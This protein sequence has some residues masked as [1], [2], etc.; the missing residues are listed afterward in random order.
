MLH[1]P[2]AALEAGLSEIRRSPTDEGRVVLIVRRPALDERE[3]LTEAELDPSTGLVGDTWPVR[4]SIR[5]PDRSPHPGMQLNIMNARVAALVAGWPAPSVVDRR[6][7]AGDQF[8]LDLD[9]SEANLPPGSRL[10]LGSAIIEVTEVPHLGCAKFSARFGPD[11]IRFVNSAAGRELRLR[12]LNARVV[13]AGTVRT[14]D[15]VSKSEVSAQRN[16]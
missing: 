8:Y 10:Q 13:A 7:Q 5:T 16:P 6:A 12:G 15:A 2:L 11:A 4:P 3:V 14:G 9:L 1:L